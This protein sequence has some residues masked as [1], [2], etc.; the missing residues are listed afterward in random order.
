MHVLFVTLNV[1]SSVQVLIL[2][3]VYLVKRDIFSLLENALK[4]VRMNILQ[5]LSY[6]SVKNA[7][8]HVQS[9]VEVKLITAL[10]V[11]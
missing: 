11:M 5:I 6:F 4:Y 2:L 7:I 10:S 9:A 3:N 1:E 8:F